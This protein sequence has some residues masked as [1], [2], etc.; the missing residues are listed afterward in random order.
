MDFNNYKYFLQC[1]ERKMFEHKLEL[2]THLR[3][4]YLFKK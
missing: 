3:K 2:F 1:I 4:K